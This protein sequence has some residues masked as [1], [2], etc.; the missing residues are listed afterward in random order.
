MWGEEVLPHFVGL[1][2]EPMP[3]RPRGSGHDMGA[4]SRNQRREEEKRKE[5]RSLW[6]QGSGALLEATAGRD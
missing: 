1:E 3:V 4:D 2:A 6:V 5:A